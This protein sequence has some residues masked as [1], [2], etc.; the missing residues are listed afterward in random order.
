MS[1]DPCPLCK[2]MLE[3]DSESPCLNLTCPNSR[4]G[5]ELRDS[6]LPVDVDLAAVLQTLPGAPPKPRPNRKARRRA[7]RNSRKHG[8]R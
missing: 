7:A 4:R 5:R 6:D 1:Y 8:R 2:G 3:G